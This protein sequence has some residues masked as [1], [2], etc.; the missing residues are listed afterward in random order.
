M[1]FR[2]L[3]TQLAQLVDQGVE[4]G[5]GLHLVLLVDQEV[6]G[7]HALLG[8]A[9]AFEQKLTVSPLLAQFKP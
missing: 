6:A 9:G 1:N 5:E 8:L 4:V 7:A 2:V 3:D